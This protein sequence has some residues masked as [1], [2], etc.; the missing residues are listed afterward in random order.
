MMSLSPETKTF[1]YICGFSMFLWLTNWS[2][3]NE[4]EQ[5]LT[6][7]DLRGLGALLGLVAS[8]ILLRR[9]WSL[10]REFLNVGI[11]VSK[12]MRLCGFWSALWLLL[13]LLFSY[14]EKLGNETYQYGG[15]TLWVSFL[16]SATAI[17]S[18]QLVVNLEVIAV[19]AASS[20]RG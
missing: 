20:G 5:S 11:V 2:Y 4:K 6:V 8:V 7:V 12:T 14:T 9:A 10:L 18:F 15:G 19:R 17:M 13:P 16:F 1:A 3:T